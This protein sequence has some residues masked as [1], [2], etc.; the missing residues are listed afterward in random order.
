MGISKGAFRRP[1]RSEIMNAKPFSELIA[2]G[3]L[4]KHL[5]PTAKWRERR[6]QIKEPL[7]D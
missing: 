1:N 6:K 7:D 2:E 5:Q 3:L 4:D